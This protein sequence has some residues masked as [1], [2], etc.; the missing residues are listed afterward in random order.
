MRKGLFKK[1]IMSKQKSLGDRAGTGQE[2]NEVAGEIIHYF[3]CSVTI[4]D[5]D[6]EEQERC[7][8]WT[9]LGKL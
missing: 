8:R 2:N 9:E 7:E 1:I 3:E 5:K 6:A 4:W